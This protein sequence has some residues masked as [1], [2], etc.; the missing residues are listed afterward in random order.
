MPDS[1]IARDPVD[2]YHI[3]SFPELLVMQVNSV[4]E[5]LSQARSPIPCIQAP[6]TDLSF[7]PPC[8]DRWRGLG[9]PSHQPFEPAIQTSQDRSGDTGAQT[10]PPARVPPDLQEAASPG[11]EGVLEQRRG[12]TKWI[13]V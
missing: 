3:G 1:E 10:F 6:A 9:P 2:H 13:H 4:Y 7:R 8:A 5:S 12:S 11:C